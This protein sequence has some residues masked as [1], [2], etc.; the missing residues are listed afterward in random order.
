MVK[1]FEI[2]Y[3]NAGYLMCIPF[4]LAA[5]ISF[6]LGLLLDKRPLLR[7]KIILSS[8]SFFTLGLLSIYLLPNIPPGTRPPTSYYLLISLQLLSVSY[9]IAMEHG[10]LSSALV[11]IVSERHFGIAWGVIGSAIGLSQA[12]GPLMAAWILEEGGDLP[13]G[14]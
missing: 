11:Y 7:R 14:Y 8:T 10:V 12:I 5:F 3:I 4:A 6:F 1:R 13:R 9:L 2:P